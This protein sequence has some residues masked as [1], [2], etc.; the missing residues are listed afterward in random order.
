MS[1]VRAGVQLNCPFAKKCHIFA[2]ASARSRLRAAG[3]SSLKD[4]VRSCSPP[5]QGVE[6]IE[7]RRPASA[8][9]FASSAQAQMF[10]PVEPPH[11]LP[12]RRPV[13][14]AAARLSASASRLSSMVMALRMR[15]NRHQMLQIVM[16]HVM[17]G[18]RSKDPAA[19]FSPQP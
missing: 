3:H 9:S 12:S 17:L 5:S 4:V 1:G 2:S 16:R 7:P 14:R 10:V 13:T 6:M 18:A 19:T 15:Q 8:I 11:N